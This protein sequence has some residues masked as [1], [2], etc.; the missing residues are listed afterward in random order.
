MPLRLGVRV[1]HHL[2]AV[3]RNAGLHRRRIPIV[4]VSDRHA[5]LRGVL[6]ALFGAGEIP[7][8]VHARRHGHVGFL[9]MRFEFVEQGLPQRFERFHTPFAVAVL[10]RHVVAY[11]LRFLVPQP[12][13][14]V[15]EG[16]AVEG[17]LLRHPF[18]A[19]NRAAPILLRCGRVVHAPKFTHARDYTGL[20]HA[21]PS[22]RQANRQ[23]P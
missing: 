14:L 4:L 5:A 11:I 19:W 9:H 8:A 12:F 23:S 15:D 10:R 20:H 17:A 2:L 16:V 6:F 18:R 21:F 3:E 1:E 7:V 13:V 22:F